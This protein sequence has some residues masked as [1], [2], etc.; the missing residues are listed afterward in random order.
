[1][2]RI[3]QTIG[4]FVAAVVLMTGCGKEW[5]DV[6]DDPNN[7]T[8]ATVQLVFPAAVTSS[9]SQ[10]GG[11]YHLIGSLWS[12][13]WTQGNSANQYNTWDAYQVL[14]TDF[15]GP[16]QELYAGALNDYRY[17][18]RN[19]MEN[20]NWSFYLMATVMESYTFQMLADVYD[21]IP[22]SEACRGD[23]GIDNP[24][25]ESGQAVYDSLIA[26]IDFA[27]EKFDET[28]SII[29]PTTSDFLFYSDG[30]TLEAEM[31]N[32]KR[33]ANTLKLKLFLRQVYAR[34]SVTNAGITAM[35]NSGAAFLDEDAAMT[36]F[37]DQP[38]KSNPLYEEDQRQLNTQ[39]NLKASTTLMSFLVENSD[40]R[41]DELYIPGAT[42]QA[43][44]DQGT[45]NLSTLVINPVNISGAH[46]SPVDPV[47]FITR[48]ESYFLQAEAV[49]RGYGS[50]DAKALY[51]EGVLAAFG[52][53][54]LDGSSFIAAAGAYEFP[55]AGTFEEKLEAIMV[56][57]WVS[58]AG[59]QGLEAFF[60]RNRT[61]YPRISP[62]PASDP[63]YVPGQITYPVAGVTG[64][65]FIKR[66]PFIDFETARNANCPD[67]VSL[68]TR[69]WWDQKN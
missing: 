7:P 49:L 35:Y 50:G 56:Q 52:R 13:Y 27:L 30:V 51:D 36:Q 65:L 69:V 43:S 67:D 18:K 45:F 8:S 19:A 3:I 54:D 58:L 14:P 12:Q 34:E 68:T 33:M 17:V 6:N 26:R 47:Y 46:L 41:L 15:N 20:E 39:S 28:T 31:D 24:H 11:Y 37:L 40:P 66:M 64:G 1:M 42:G 9:A 25:Y 32:W 53:Y 38:S 29:P 5:L 2:K 57:K 44:M 23:E 55:S 16:Y 10:L 48:A 63:A 61:G 59:A 4:L 62:V 21:Q 60:E 22:F